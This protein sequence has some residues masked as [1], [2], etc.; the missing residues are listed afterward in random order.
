MRMDYS[1]IKGDIIDHWEQLSE[2]AH[3]EDLLT[4]LGESACPVYYSDI[5]KDW[6]EMPN[7]YTDSWQEFVHAE[8]DTTI[9]SLMG[10]DLWNYYTNE[11]RRVFAEVRQDKEQE[12][13]ELETA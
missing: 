10:W 6:Q 1:D 12:E 5:I 8:Q 2:M 9:F 7:E 3:P 13:N 11:Y 4:E